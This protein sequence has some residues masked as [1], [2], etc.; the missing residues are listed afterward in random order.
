MAGTRTTQVQYE[1]IDDSINVL[2]NSIND[3]YIQQELG[4]LQMQIDCSV[5]DT[6]EQLMIAA[7]GVRDAYQTIIDLMIA[8]KDMLQTAKRL[9]RD[10]DDA[11]SVELGGE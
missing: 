6:P 4:R 1:V 3:I 8:S 5:G 2:N 9:F 7:Q 10:C 11:V